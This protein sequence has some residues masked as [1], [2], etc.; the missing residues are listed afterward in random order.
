MF[1]G[2]PTQCK[3]LANKTLSIDPYI[4]E[5]DTVIN[6]KAVSTSKKTTFPTE[7]SPGWLCVCVYRENDEH[8]NTMSLW[9]AI[10]KSE[11]ECRYHYYLNVYINK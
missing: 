2:K 10:F 1:R 3:G 4:R 8:V 6:I 11:S 7:M 5:F 9:N